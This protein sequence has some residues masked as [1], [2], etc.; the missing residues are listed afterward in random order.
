MTRVVHC[1]REPY[2]TMIDRTTMFGNRHYIC[3]TC[4]REQSI[5]RFRKDFNERMETDPD[6]RRHIL[7]L[8]GLTLGCWCKPKACH[9][10]VIAEYLNNRCKKQ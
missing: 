8:A 5:E 10:D 6:Y 3:A 4:T 1:R 7:A 9:G 2:D